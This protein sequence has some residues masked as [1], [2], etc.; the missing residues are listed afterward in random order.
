MTDF[1]AELAAKLA[2]NAELARQ[3]AEA[4]AAMD[5]AVRKREVAEERRK[6]ELAEARLKRHA[7]LVQHLTSVANG[8][9]S[10]SPEEFVVRLGWTHSG[11]EFIAKISTRKLAPTRALLIELDRDDDEVLARWRSDLGDSLELWRLLEVEPPLLAQLVLQ[12]A[13]QELWKNRS[14]PPPF[15]KA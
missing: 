14:A 9:K 13:D 2:R 6:R 12:V 11:E 4:E 8:L 15:P 7:D 1:E 5:R 10:A 3:R